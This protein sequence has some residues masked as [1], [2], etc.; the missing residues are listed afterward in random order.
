[1][2]TAPQALLLFDAMSL[3]S[4]DDRGTWVT[5]AIAPGNSRWEQQ[6]R[7]HLLYSP[8]TWCWSP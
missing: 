3:R 8:C 4:D 7:H 6:P 2:P 1:M 5:H